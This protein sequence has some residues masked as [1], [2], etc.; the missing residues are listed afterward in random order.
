MQAKKITP[1]GKA[2]NHGFAEQIL[3]ERTIQAMLKTCEQ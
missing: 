1:M 3:H 2:E